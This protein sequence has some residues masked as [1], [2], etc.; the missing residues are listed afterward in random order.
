MGVIYTCA[1]GAIE[2]YFCF[3]KFLMNFGAQS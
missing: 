1:E 2:S 3:E